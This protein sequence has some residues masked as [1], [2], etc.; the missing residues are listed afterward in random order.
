M[1]RRTRSLGT[2]SSI[3]LG[4]PSWAYI[5]LVVCLAVLTSPL[6]FLDPPGTFRERQV[7]RF[8]GATIWLSIGMIAYIAGRD[9]GRR[10]ILDRAGRTVSRES[11]GPWR[12]TLLWSYPGHRIEAVFLERDPEGLA[13]LRAS[14][15]GGPKLLIERAQNEE[16]L[17]TLGRDLAVCWDVPFNG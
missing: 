12:S 14:V 3:G 1:P 6:W 5:P 11:N 16:D 8:A 13:S 10:L 9:W 15:R 4:R 17:K 2:T 7:F